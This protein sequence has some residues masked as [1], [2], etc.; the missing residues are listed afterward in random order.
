MRLI[1][2]TVIILAVVTGFLI[3]SGANGGAS[4]SKTVDQVVADQSL[5]GKQVK[6]AGKV[7]NG[8]WDKKTD[9]M[10]FKMVA[11]SD[12]LG[13]GPAVQVTYNGASPSTFGDGVVAIVTGTLNSGGKITSSDM[14]TKCPSKYKSA[15]GAIPV[16]DLQPVNAGQAIQVTGFVVPGSIKPAGQAQR[17]ALAAAADGSGKTVPVAYDAALVSGMKDGSKL[18]ITGQLGKNGTFTATEIALATK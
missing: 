6:V 11:E 17:F 10:I 18:V 4:Y 16:Q 14:I 8:S 9:P 2:V 1:A 5:V 15:Q 3:Y 7:V 12:T 13:T